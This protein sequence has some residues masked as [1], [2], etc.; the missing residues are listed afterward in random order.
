MSEVKG[1]RRGVEGAEQTTWEYLFR[2]LEPDEPVPPPPPEMAEWGSI[3]GYGLTF[4]MLYGGHR[5][6]KLSRNRSIPSPSGIK[7]KAQRAGYF[8]GMNSIAWGAR[9]G[10]FVSLFSAVDIWSRR[11]KKGEW[12]EK[13]VGG[14]VVSGIFAMMR[15]GLSRWVGVGSLMGGG[16]GS[17]LGLAQQCLREIA[18]KN[19]VQDGESEVVDVNE[20]EKMR[21]IVS[22]SSTNAV[23]EGLEQSMRRNPAYAEN[24][25]SR[26]ASNKDD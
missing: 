24:K 2:R 18:E 16:L 11:F 14:G 20:E 13:G 1:V 3:L 26:N 22:A 7:T 5:G 25:N 23:I 8:F 17:G 19:E 6:L 12:F 10:L 4:G 9:V 15:F 21:K